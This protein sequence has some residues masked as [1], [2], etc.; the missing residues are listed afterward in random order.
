MKMFAEETNNDCD[1]ILKKTFLDMQLLYAVN[2]TNWQTVLFP[3]AIY[4]SDSHKR[5][6]FRQDPTPIMHTRFHDQGIPRQKYKVGKKLNCRQ[7]KKF[8]ENP[9]KHLK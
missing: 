4:S 2:M 5:K 9:V 8:I 3:R 6:K 1:H 7:I